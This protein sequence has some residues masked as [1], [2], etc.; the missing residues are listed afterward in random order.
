[1]SS[2]LPIEVMRDPDVLHRLRDRLRDL[3]LARN[4]QRRRT[5][6]AGSV[7]TLNSCIL[8]L[9]ATIWHNDHTGQPVMRS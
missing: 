8:A 9:I 6:S 2:R 5:T 4:P 1:M 3:S 7:D